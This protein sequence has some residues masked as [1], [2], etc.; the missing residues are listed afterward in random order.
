MP[1]NKASQTDFQS[2]A[3]FI[4]KKRN[5]TA[6]LFQPLLAALNL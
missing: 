1:L 4:A 3:I 5:K 6:K 2:L